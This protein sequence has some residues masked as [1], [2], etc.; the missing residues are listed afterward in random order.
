MGAPYPVSASAISGISPNA[1]TIIRARSAISVAVTKPM[2]GNPK[3]E[4]ATPAPVM[5][6]ATWPVRL[7]SCAEMPSKT[8]G[9]MIN[10][11]LSS[12]SFSRWR[13][14]VLVMSV[15]SV[16]CAR[17]GIGEQVYQGV[18]VIECL[19]ADHRPL[20]RLGASA[21]GYPVG[22]RMELCDELLV[23]DRVGGRAVP[24]DDTGPVHGAVPRGYRDIGSESLG[25]VGRGERFVEVHRR[26]RDQRP[27]VVGIQTA[28]GE[29]L[30]QHVAVE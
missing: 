20:D 11:C 19:E 15:L 30:R 22:E 2:S 26:C 25:D 6:A 4:A 17:D 12:S 8:P 3:P 16:Q 24:L 18:D 21:V 23:G 7:V 13:A 28:G 14:R 5:Y 9:A 29:L 27:D 10:S 1:P